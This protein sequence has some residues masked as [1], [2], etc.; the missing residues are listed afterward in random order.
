MRRQGCHPS[1]RCA[2]S[3]STR[4]TPH[5]CSL[6]VVPISQEIELSHNAPDPLA[7]ASVAP[8]RY[9]PSTERAKNELGLRETVGWLRQFVVLFHGIGDSYYAF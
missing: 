3:A 1:S 5:S 9:V 2:F 8:S 4:S 7:P 6:G